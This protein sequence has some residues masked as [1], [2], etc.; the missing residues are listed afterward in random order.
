MDTCVY[1]IKAKVMNIKTAT[2]PVLTQNLIEDV[3]WRDEPQ[4]SV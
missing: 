2:K 1:Q 4:L 3:H